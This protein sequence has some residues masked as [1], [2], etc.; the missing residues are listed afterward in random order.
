[1]RVSSGWITSHGF[2]LNVTTDLSY[3]GSIVPCGI[4]QYG[5]SSIARLR[6]APPPVAEVEDAVVHSFCNVFG[7]TI[8]E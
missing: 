5:V 1:V 3:F 8:I 4:T 7:S 6:G 2:A